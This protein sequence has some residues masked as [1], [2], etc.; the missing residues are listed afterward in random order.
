MQ[1]VL[2]NSGEGHLPERALIEM[3]GDLEVLANNHVGDLH[4]AK[5][6]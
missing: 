4:F 3:Q 1:L 6:V 5:D 2:I